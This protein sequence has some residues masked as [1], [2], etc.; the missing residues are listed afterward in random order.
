[1]VNTLDKEE[2]RIKLEEINKLVEKKDYKG[3]MEIVDS[4]D[5]KK[6]KNARTLSIVGEIY[7]ANKRY[8]ESMEIFLLAYERAGIGKNILSRLIDIALKMNRFDEA[9]EFYQEFEEI[10][11]NDN[12]K[13][14]LK[15]KILKAKNAPLEEQIP[16][17]E[18][19]KEREFTEKWAYELAKLYY[20]AGEKEKCIDLC[21]TIILWFSEGIYV[22]RSM[23]LK[24]R[25]GVMSK[26]E[27][28]KYGQ[29]FTPKLMNQE[30][31]EAL[32]ENLE[33]QD[34]EEPE[35]EF[36]DIDKIKIEKSLEKASDK[37]IEKLLNDQEEKAGASGNFQDKIT[38][39]LR[40]LFGG[41][42]K[43]LDEE[44]DDD[45]F[46]DLE[47]GEK[48]YKQQMNIRHGESDE[49]E[50]EDVPELEHEELSS[51]DYEIRDEKMEEES[52]FFTEIDPAEEEEPEEEENTRQ[53]TLEE[54]NS[55]LMKTSS[56]PDPDIIRQIMD[57]RKQTEEEAAASREEEPEKE[58]FNLEDMILSA[59]TAQGINLGMNQEK[60]PEEEPVLE[61]A[62]ESDAFEASE[63][64]EE[65]L[66][67]LTEKDTQPSEEDGDKPEPLAFEKMKIPE[68]IVEP[69]KPEIPKL[70]PEVLEGL[71]AEIGRK[72]GETPDLL[73]EL[74][75]DL[76]EEE[77]EED[78]SPK[79]REFS[80]KVEKLLS[81]DEIDPEKMTEEERLE[82]FIDN[83]NAV[84]ENPRQIIPRQRKLRKE[85]EK[86]FSYFVK[87]P[88]MT[89]QLLDVLCD[90]QNSA[91]DKTSKTGNIIV[92]GARETGK[93][94][95]IS[96]IIPAICKELH[97]EAAK[98]AYVF[99]DQIN[100]KDI[101]KIVDKL[102][103]G[104]L[105]IENANQLDQETA[106]KL[107]QAME[108]RTDGLTVILEDEKIGMRKFM[109]RYEKLSKK[110]TSIINIPVFTNDELVNF[111]N[112]YTLENGYSIDQMGMLALYNSISK[113][114]KADEPM[115]I[116]NVKNMIDE[117]IGKSQSGMRKIFSKKRTDRD[118][119]LVLGEKDFA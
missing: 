76:Q 40:D 88:G 51:D 39:G 57:E 94:H 29:Q 47:F 103:G 119:L 14:V 68:K 53:E 12:S 9:E 34:A 52:D 104:F 8:E 21:N 43:S 95:L 45:I 17:L 113:N 116:G 80:D 97:M 4:I 79:L 25:L 114:Q 101:A 89:D 28:E 98:V 49:D 10:A 93:T 70:E 13:Y 27:K 50:T 92:M 38:K 106:E 30:E 109:A 61:E 1:M 100:G 117:A 7:A 84:E 36:S 31:L 37:S 112:I 48:E 87:V 118:G 46:G 35:E 105:V 16:L 63:I 86:L 19:Y 72:I 108:F 75:E 90:M 2:F 54:S 85:E 24:Q 56:L 96:S 18:E 111:A 42:K 15:Y 26:E 5:W 74:K 107:N 11:A 23:D 78:L 44:D 91:A 67:F 20:K 22:T 66:E 59:A 41:K 115:T 83:M 60:E 64:S 3:A 65:E 73:G 71:E 99:A 81:E 62:E 69:V 77:P 55:S 6:V 102:S 32:R 82:N 110:F 58:E 33:E